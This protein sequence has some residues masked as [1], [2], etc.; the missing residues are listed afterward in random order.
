MVHYKDQQNDVYQNYLHHRQVY[1]AAFRAL[2][3]I[4]KIF[5]KDGVTPLEYVK[6]SAK[7]YI[8]N[9]LNIITKTSS[10]KGNFRFK[11]IPDGECRLTFERDYYESQ[12][13]ETEVHHQKAKSFKISMQKPM[14]VV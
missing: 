13:I 1:D 8:G 6:I 3:L 5:E 12:S 10:K 9:R 7:Y 14:P 2:S 11:G 4:G